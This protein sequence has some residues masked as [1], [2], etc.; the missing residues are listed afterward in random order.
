MVGMV[1]LSIIGD[2]SNVHFYQPHI[3]VVEEQLGNNPSFYS[4]CKL[5]YSDRYVSNLEDYKAERITFDEF[6]GS[7]TYEDFYFENYQSFPS[8]K[9]DMFAPTE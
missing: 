6:I 9:A 5:T 8:L 2:L 3:E 4:G 1:P 7:L